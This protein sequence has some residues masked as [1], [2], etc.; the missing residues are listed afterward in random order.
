MA[1]FAKIVRINPETG[2]VIDIIATKVG[3]DEYKDFIKESEKNPDAKFYGL[4]LDELNKDQHIQIQCN[5]SLC[6]N[7]CKANVHAAETTNSEGSSNLDT[8][9]WHANKGE[10]D[11]HHYL[12]IIAKPNS[13]WPSKSKKGIKS[14]KHAL[15]KWHD[16]LERNKSP[17]R[18]LIN[19]N[20]EIGETNKGTFSKNSNTAYNIWRNRHK[21]QYYSDRAHNFE[22]LIK[23]IRQIQGTTKG[24]AFQDTVFHYNQ[25]LMHFA[26]MVLTINKD[27]SIAEHKEIERQRMISLFRA[28]SNPEQHQNRLLS[29][30]KNGLILRAMPS[31]MRLR[32]TEKT[33]EKARNGDW[34]RRGPTE[35]FTN[36]HKISLSEITGIPKDSTAQEIILNHKI[37]SQSPRLS[38]ELLGTSNSRDV[39]PIIIGT[40]TIDVHSVRDAFKR[41]RE[42]DTKPIYVN[43]NWDIK[44]ASQVFIPQPSVQQQTIAME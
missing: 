3:A 28:M 37:I 18:I 17:L 22:E 20:F 24:Q 15:E 21:G 5:S 10:K 42:G 35:F 12:D 25:K 43:I 34:K 23:Q 2:D 38:G 16:R 1:D 30:H 14:L 26:E 32:F 29:G 4:T 6:H 13:E 9:I 27:P 11:K 40:P 8:H 44:D 33:Q 36:S 19:L 31:I 41:A 39:T 7:D